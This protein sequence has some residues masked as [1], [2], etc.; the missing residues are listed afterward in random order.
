MN[1]KCARVIEFTKSTMKIESTR[2]QRALEHYFFEVG[3]SIRKAVYQNIIVV[4][5]A[6]TTSND[7]AL[8]LKRMICPSF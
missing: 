1:A 8:Q 3:V 4:N 6:F 2:G 7:T 5:S